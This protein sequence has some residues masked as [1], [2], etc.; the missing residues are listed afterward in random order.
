MKLEEMLIRVHPGSGLV[1]RYPGV[2]LTVLT[3]G[4]PSPVID[5]LLDLAA[6]SA[7]A[8]ETP[9]RRLARRLAGLVS[10]VDPDE[11]PGLCAV[12][13]TETG[14]AVFVAGPLDVA[15]TGPGGAERFSG[16]QAATWVDRVIDQPFDLIAVTPSGEQALP[17]GD[18]RFNLRE[19][20]VPGAGFT[21][22][23]AGAKAATPPA[24]PQPPAAAP[25]MEAAPA[26]APVAAPAAPAPVAAVDPARATASGPPVAFSPVSLS[27]PDEPRAPLPVAGQD[28]HPAD[29]PADNGAAGGAAGGVIVQGVECSRGHFG[30]P[31]SNFCGVCGISML[32]RTLNLRSGIRPP[33]GVLVFEDGAT[34]SLDGDYVIGREPGGDPAVQSSKARPLVLNDPDRS[35]SRVHA[36]IVLEGWAVTIVDHGSANGTYV[37]PPNQTAETAL[38]ART[39]TRIA[40]GTR[41]RVGDRTFLFETHTKG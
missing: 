26:P 9:G 16:S 20:V 34:F 19:G 21:L 29:H 5:Q 27:E 28:D 7:A 13:Q 14:V 38:L 11:L 3:S 39:P 40:P 2:A 24:P 32:H 22:R 30:S 41:V 33:L 6:E 37:T 17:D 35:V 25:V 31:D 10:Q 36:G 8:S 18:S 23:P 1:A 4:D 15:V 12:S